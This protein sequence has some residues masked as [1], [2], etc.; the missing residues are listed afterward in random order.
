MPMLEQ[1]G[2]CDGIDLKHLCDLFPATPNKA[3]SKLAFDRGFS[4]RRMD[5]KYSVT[6]DLTSHC[7]IL[8]LG[9]FGKPASP[10]CVQKSPNQM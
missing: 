1:H 2:K 6:N 5:V 4:V 3:I 7:G 8:L 10:T 9:F